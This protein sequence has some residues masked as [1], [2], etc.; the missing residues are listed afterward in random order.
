MQRMPALENMANPASRG[1][2]PSFSIV[3]VAAFQMLAGLLA[4]TIFPFAGWSFYLPRRVS[5]L[6]D[7]PQVL[8]ALLVIAFLV[9]VTATGLWRLRVWARR[10]W[11]GLS[12]V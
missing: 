5:V 4:L 12:L 9:I 2:R 10:L 6:P 11:L 7:A 3:A 1:P 8:G